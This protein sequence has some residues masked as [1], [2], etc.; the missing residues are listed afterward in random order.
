[1]ILFFAAAVIPPLLIAY[2]VYQQDKYDKEP[3]SLLIKSFLF[4]C[5]SVV[6]A[7]ILEIILDANLFSNL[8]LYVFIG[9]ALVEEGVKFFFLRGYMYQK[10]EFNEPMDGIVYGVMISLGFA[11]VENVVY[12]FVYSDSG[13]ELQTAILRMFTAIPLHAVCGIILGYYVGLAKFSN[14]YKILLYKGLLF[15]VLTHTLY[16]YFIMA[17]YGILLSIIALIIAI[18][19]SKKAINLHQDDS[20]QRNFFKKSS[21]FFNK[22]FNK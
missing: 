17:G 1:M 8:F 14:N 12:V 13:S 4:G 20:K 15:A 9:I 7:L 3:R 16:N 18:Y 22:Y 5:V 19:F 11:T 2:Y 6:P 21:L 10:E